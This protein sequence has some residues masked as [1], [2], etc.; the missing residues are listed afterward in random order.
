MRCRLGANAQADGS[1]YLEQG[2]TKVL[3]TVCGPHEAHGAARSGPQHNRAALMCEVVPLPFATGQHRARS[4]RH[5]RASSELAA[6]VRAV[7]E[8]VVQVALYP[9]SQIDVTISLLQDDGDVRSAAINATMLALVDAGVTLE[10][11]VC[12]SSTGSVHGALL[13]DPNGQEEGAGAKLSVAYLPNSERISLALVEP[14][15]PLAS[16]E[17]ALQFAVTGCR[18]AYDVLR[19]AVQ[20]RMQEQLSSRGGVID[21]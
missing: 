17:E 4:G 13:L 11:F 6:Q 18:Q 1:S 12:A 16:Y 21:R 8:H 15:L 2:N 5:D 3:V 20:T 10:D 7:F 9:H 14:K 19:A